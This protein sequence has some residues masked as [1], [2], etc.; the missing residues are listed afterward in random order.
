MSVFGISLS[1]VFFV[2]WDFGVLGLVPVCFGRNL[3]D[4]RFLGFVLD[5][6]Y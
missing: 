1:V 3:L 6:L 5:G 4:L 2:V